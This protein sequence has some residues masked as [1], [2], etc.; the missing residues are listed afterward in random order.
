MGDDPE[1]AELVLSRLG[2]LLR[3][4]LQEGDRGEVPLERE[5]EFLER[6]TE[7]QRVRFAD[8]LSVVI[9]VPAECRAGLVPTLL[10]QPLVENAIRHGIEPRASRGTVT[11][12]ARREGDTLRVWI[13][14]DGIGI[15]PDG[16]NGLATDGHGVG[17]AN[18]RQRL[19]QLHGASHVFTVG[20]RTGGGTAVEITL[21]WREEGE[22]N[23]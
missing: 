17:L 18:T 6:Y 11:V 2:D 13:H 19:E 8:R 1:R 5:L 15:G 20:Q 9:D 12:G 22:R 3:L 10:L 14:D 23:A 7:I 21:P 16:R 4:T